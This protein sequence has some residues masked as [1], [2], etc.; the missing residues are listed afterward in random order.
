MQLTY[1]AQRTP[2]ERTMIRTDTYRRVVHRRR[3]ALFAAVAGL[4]C[5]VVVAGLVASGCATKPKKPVIPAKYSTV[6]LRKV[7]PFLAD[8]ILQKTDIADTTPFI[9]NGYGLVANLDQT[10][11][12]PYP[13]RVRDHMVKEMMRHGFG[14]ANSSQYAQVKPERALESKRF[15]VVEVRGLIPPGA[16][17]GQQFDVLVNTLPS[18]DATS[19]SRGTLYQTDLKMLGLRETAPE[20]SVNVYARGQGPVFVNPA[21]ALNDQS[22][23]TG[24]A[25]LSLRNGMVLA[26]GN[27]MIDRPIRLQLRQ[28]QRSTARQIESRINTYFQDV[29]DK[30]RRDSA[31]PSYTVAEAQDE[32]I[33]SLYVPKSF[34][35]DW[36][37][38]IN[39]VQ[40]LYR[41]G[42]PRFAAEQARKLADEAV[43]PNAPLR[44][45]SFAWEGLG[46]PA[47]PFVV[48]LM[49]ATKYAPDV[50]YAAARAAAY[51]GDAV[52]PEAL[53]AMAKTPNHPFQLGAAQ[54]LA[55]LPNSPNHN[56]MLRDLLD[57]PQ[58]PVRV[59]AYKALARN[60]DSIIYTKV[61]NESFV[62]DIV[63]SNGPSLIYASR[64]GLPRIALFGNR[65]S[66][67][68]PIVFMALNSEFQISSDESGKF[69]NLFYRGRDIGKP[70]NIESGPDVGEIIARLGGEGPVEERR[71]RFSYG[72]IVAIV[73]GLADQHRLSAV[74]GAGATARRVPT[75][76]VLQEAG[77]IEDTIYAAPAI[78]GTGRPQQAEPEGEPQAAGN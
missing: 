59:T 6:E 7:P 76:F 29:A 67:D 57:S 45:I 9:V 20:G 47:L 26:G 49:D 38:F 33:I 68:R 1:L 37:H 70:L 3:I 35:G 25:R 11:G 15:A 77:S 23:T 53:L 17:Q 2:E 44:N 51:L 71:F 60:R 66:V 10:G 42:S 18:S 31:V 43:K 12:G 24:G 28:P 63:P 62:L 50:T 46:K 55:T 22:A 5:S 74:V 56:R 41:D 39:V 58:T 27:C 16:R 72:E 54:T 21:Y 69:V 34:D 61:V 52:A 64:E 78:P 30:F 48:P 19:L 36:E 32:G 13:T 8:T 65:V 73:Q 40:H 75:T 4:A 14:S